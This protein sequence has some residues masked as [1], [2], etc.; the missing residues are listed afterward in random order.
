MAADPL[1]GP[2]ANP[3]TATLVRVAADGTTR[4]AASGL[5]L[6][7]GMAQLNDGT[8]LVA[9]T[10][11]G[12]ITCVHPGTRWH[13]RRSTRLGRPAFERRRWGRSA[14]GRPV[15]VTDSRYTDDS[16]AAALPP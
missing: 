14:A 6:P 9:E 10:V 5:G 7:N 15:A 2:G 11:F 16:D 1:F 13:A 12:R 8:L 3:P 4:A